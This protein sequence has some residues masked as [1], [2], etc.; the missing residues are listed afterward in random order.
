ME[1]APM[2]LTPTNGS[3]AQLSS[4]FLN[5]HS[6]SSSHVTRMLSATSTSQPTPKFLLQIFLAL[7]LPSATPDA[8]FTTQVFPPS[9]SH[10]LYFHLTGNPLYLHPHVSSK[11]ADFFSRLSPIPGHVTKSQQEGIARTPHIPNTLSSLLYTAPNSAN[12]IIFGR[13]NQRSFLPKFNFFP[14]PGNKLFSDLA[15]SRG[16][17]RPSC[18]ARLKSSPLFSTYGNAIF[19]VAF[20]LFSLC[21][22]I[23]GHPGWVSDLQHLSQCASCNI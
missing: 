15:T 23:A 5:M 4:H 11:Q 6:H 16:Q 13:E 21:I 14:S 10:Q 2:H 17:R 7:F 9:G 18:A 22:S 3:H 1:I 19:Q 8:H 12:W 20:L